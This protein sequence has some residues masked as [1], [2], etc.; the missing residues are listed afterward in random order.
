MAIETS[1]ALN[2][3]AYVVLPP[4]SFEFMKIVFLNIDRSVKTVRASLTNRANGN[5]YFGRSYH[6]H[7]VKA[8]LRN[9]GNARTDRGP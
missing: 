5:T 9:P 1:S 6:V 7:A 8:R 4:K 2:T 3:K